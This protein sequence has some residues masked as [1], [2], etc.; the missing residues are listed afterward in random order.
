MSNWQPNSNKHKANHCG[1]RKKPSRKE[2]NALMMFY[3]GID[4]VER[5][6]PVREKEGVQ[7][8]LKL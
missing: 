8:K 4:A 7:L 3:R 1:Y 6:T 2:V 5:I